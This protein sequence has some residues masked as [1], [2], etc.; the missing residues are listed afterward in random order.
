[1]YE[2]LCK[3][4]GKEHVMKDQHVYKQTDHFKKARTDFPESFY[5]FIKIILQI[6]IKF[7][8]KFLKFIRNFH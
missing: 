2:R 7:T 4:Y 3:V 6:L 1:M 5:N 8:F